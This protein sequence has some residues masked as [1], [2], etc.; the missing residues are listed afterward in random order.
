MGTQ[1]MGKT[2][3]FY[4]NGYGV[5]PEVM[6]DANYARYLGQVLR[7]VRRE[8]GPV[9]LYLAG[10]ATNPLLPGRTEAAAMEQLVREFLSF[11]PAPPSLDIVRLEAATDLRGNLEAF[12]AHAGV[13]VEAAVFC[14]YARQDR[15]RF[16]VRRLLPRCRVH[17]LTFD[18][19]Q[20]P[21]T[22]DRLR[23]LPETLLHVLAWYV[24]PLRPLVLTPL[25]A[26][27]MRRDA[28]RRARPSP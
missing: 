13:N 18:Q 27:H 17:P 28:V 5:P 25:R 15:V 24:P 26:R 21:R 6:E 12:R 1:T 9:R 23:Q 16:Y 4:V 22:A 3:I 20:Y 2:A 19:D 11:G 14:E 8:D 10:G 7:R